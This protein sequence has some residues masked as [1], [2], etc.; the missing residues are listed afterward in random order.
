MNERVLAYKILY[1]FQLSFDRLDNIE[2]K[3]LSSFTLSSNQNRHLKNVV[4]GVLRHQLLLDWYISKLY[5]GDFKKL[6]EKA[7]CVLQIGFYEFLFMDHIP[8]HATVNECVKLTKSQI[9]LKT[10]KL[11]NAILRN[12]LRQKDELIISKKEDLHSNLSVLYSFPNWLIKRWISYWGK[13]IT[14]ELCSSLNEFPVF[15]VRINKQKITSAEFENLLK[16][17]DIEFLK[18]QINNNCFQIKKISEIKKA[19]FFDSGLC[20]VQDESAMIPVGLFEFIEDDSY[21]DVCAAPGSKFT[22][23]LEQNPKLKLAIAVDENFGRLKRVK[24]NI[25]RLGLNGYVIAADAKNLPFKIKFS[26]LLIDA[27]CSGLGV[28]GKHPDIKWRRTGNDIKEFSMLQK[29]ILENA[30]KF[31]LK[32]GSVVYSTCSIDKEENENVINY[33]LK[34]NSSEYIKNENPPSKANKL[35]SFIR[36]GFIQTF[37]HKHKM[38]GSFACLLVKV[39]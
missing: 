25:K 30:S 16:E 12:Y 26:K 3:V 2:N 13:D 17:N 22:Q 29:S 31:V 20:S 33:F 37:P 35:Q 28:I 34:S 38:D 18:S 14:E 39:A 15:N 24:E 36:D 23:V 6:I 19:G 32:N 9:N 1:Q 5:K 21:L 27:P 7:R 8:D 4:S 11:V 10:S